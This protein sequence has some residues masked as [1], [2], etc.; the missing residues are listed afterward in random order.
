MTVK[1][2]F[3]T[4][5]WVLAL[6]VTAGMSTNA[7]SGPSGF[8]CPATGRLISVGQSQVEVRNRCGEPDE[9]RPSVDVRTVRETVRRWVN[10]VA[11]EVTVEH[12]IEVPVDEWTYDFG[13]NRFIQFLHFEYGRLISVL[14]GGK[15]GGAP[16]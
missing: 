10:G 6:G 13:R 1:D 4:V 11:H 9:T 15:G 3:K 8:R 2:T 16:Q 12:T 14:E 7:K 5:T